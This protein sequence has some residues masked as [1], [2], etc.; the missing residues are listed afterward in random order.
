MDGLLALGVIVAVVA[1]ALVALG[2]WHR[3]A[4]MRRRERS[5]VEERLQI[6]RDACA[7]NVAQETIVVWLDEVRQRR[8]IRHT[9]GRP[10]RP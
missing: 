10:V 1:G 8:R 4:R 6:V 7:P 3:E 2:G 5:L 9:S